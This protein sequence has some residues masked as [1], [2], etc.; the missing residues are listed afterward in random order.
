M[1]SGAGAEDA[2]GLR[3]TLYICTV[4]YIETGNGKADSQTSRDAASSS[5]E[6]LHGTLK[7]WSI[8]PH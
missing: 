7:S 4:S 8:L 2:I 1:C 5:V 6:Y 3:K